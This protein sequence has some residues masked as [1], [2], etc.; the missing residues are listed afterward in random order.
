M[1][2]TEKNLIPWLQDFLV[3]RLNVLEGKLDGFQIEFRTEIHRLDDK[4][5]GVKEDVRNLRGELHQT[6]GE[7]HQALDGV[8]TDVRGLR[9]EFRLAIDMH[10]RI[11]TIEAK[12]GLAH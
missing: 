5:D 3:P 6:R 4:M 10:E 1:K 11:A 12:I 7:I 9:E 2:M 8:K